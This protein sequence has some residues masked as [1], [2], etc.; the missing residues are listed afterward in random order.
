MAK[1]DKKKKERE[2]RKKRRQKVLAQIDENKVRETVKRTLAKLDSGKKKKKF[3]KQKGEAQ[4]LPEEGNVLYVPTSY[5][6]AELSDK[7]KQNSTD[8]IKKCIELGYMV[9]INQRLDF[10]IIKII[11]EAYDFEVR[12]ADE[13]IVEEEDDEPEEMLETR[14]P[15][16]TI[17]GHVDHGKTTLLDY[18]RDANVVAG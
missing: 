17:M 13:Y 7:L 12:P 3:K 9:T 1:T 15:I 2:A 5:T 16:I 18:I 6:V 10:D 4:T 11:A 14:A 8:I